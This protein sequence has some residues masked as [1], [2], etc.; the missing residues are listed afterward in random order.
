MLKLWV[1][2][3]VKIAKKAKINLERCL[4]IMPLNE[5]GK[6]LMKA[7]KKQYGDKKGDENFLCYGK[8]WQ[9]KKSYKSKRW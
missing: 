6:K 4:S 9:I 8:F 2:E 5:K 1:N 7:M 3:V